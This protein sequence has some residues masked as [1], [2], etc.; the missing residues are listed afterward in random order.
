MPRRFAHAIPGH[1]AENARHAAEAGD[2]REQ[3]TGADEAGQSV[4]AGRGQCAQRDADQHQTAGAD[5]NLPHDVDRLFAV[6]RDRQAGFFPGIETAFEDE[7]FAGLRRG[8]RQSGGVAFGAR[9]GT[10]VENQHVVAGARRVVGVDSAEGMMTCAGNAFARMFVGFADIDEH[11][12][13]AD[14]FGGARR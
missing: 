3:Q 11:G 5:L 8:A 13:G 14:E 9:A 7:S 12:T 6:E 1:R 10:A 4:E 2:A